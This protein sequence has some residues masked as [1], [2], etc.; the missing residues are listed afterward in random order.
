[1]ADPHFDVQEAH[2]HFSKDCFNRAWGLIDKSERTPEENEQMAQLALASLWH[3][4]QRADCTDKNLSVGY[5][6]ASR[7]YSLLGEGANAQKYGYL[8]LAKTP[9]DD[10]FL[11]GYAQEALARAAF[12]QCQTD[13]A[14][15]HQTEGLKL[16]EQVAEADSQQMLI[17]D[18]K[19]IL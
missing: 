13:K 6:Q 7:I 14:R 11:L 3:W 12:A 4:S 17:K 5:W 18:L 16:A 8:C 2:Q 9:Q 1:M 10:P 19:G 15:E